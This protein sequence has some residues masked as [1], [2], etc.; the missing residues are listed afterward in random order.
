MQSALAGN[1]YNVGGQQELIDD[2][3]DGGQRPS[4]EEAQAAY[5]QEYHNR[6]P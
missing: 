6:P 4:K 1:G 5:E 2:E 3:A